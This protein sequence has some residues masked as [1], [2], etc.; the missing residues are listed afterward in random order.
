MWQWRKVGAKLDS[1]ET[2]DDALIERV[3]A[4]QMAVLEAEVGGNFFAAGKY[5][6]AAEVFTTLTLAEQLEPFL[7]LP[8]YAR[9]FAR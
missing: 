5:K 7:T 9:Y 6:E 8:A 2:V 3:V 4:E 1:G